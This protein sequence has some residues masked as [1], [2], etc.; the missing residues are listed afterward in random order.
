MPSRPSPP[1]QLLRT[2][3]ATPRA[4]GSA[5][6][7]SARRECAAQLAALGYVTREHAFDFSSFP[8]RF[9]TPLA[10]VA[11]VLLLATAAHVGARGDRYLPLALFVAGGVLLAL[12]GS[13]MARHG[14]LSLP[15]GRDGGVNLEAALEGDAPT[16]WLCAHL[17]SKSQPVPTLVRTA[18]VFLLVLGALTVLA[19]ALAAALGAQPSQTLWAG[20]ALL[21]LVGGV[22]VVLSVVGSRSNGALDNA[23][24]VA[25][26]IAA[27][28][29][30][31]DT[32]GI[33]VLI[34]DAE[35][36]GLAGA[37]AW[38]REKRKMS[39]LNCDG[40]DDTGEINVLFTGR[41]PAGLLHAA[42]TVS[43]Q[44]AIPCRVRRIPMGILMDSIAFADAGL[45]AVTFSR[46]TYRSLARVHS[47]ADSLENLHGTGVE[48][49]AVLMAATA[50]MLL[51][52]A[53]GPTTPGA[54][55]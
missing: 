34:T 16:V 11:A 25:T 7:D 36:L 31:R 2:L 1:D 13:W 33:G 19:L 49:T 46:G 48:P 27:A 12:V 55:S 29:R 41:P 10:G 5:T 32:R 52:T 47:A 20:S 21:T 17:D 4:T 35:E 44:L 18:G 8:G 30:V 39:V 14:V 23:S 9:G 43:Q 26:V 6:L 15:V 28:E 40:V 45:D 51:R 42:R 37:R 3:A 53:A 38:A 22:P 24:G 54:T 50:R